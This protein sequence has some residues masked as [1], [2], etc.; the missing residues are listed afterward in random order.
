MIFI[1]K[2]GPDANTNLQRLKDQIDL[3]PPYM[4]FESVFDDE[5]GK[6]IKEIRNATKMRH[7]ITRNEIITKSK[8]TS[9]ESA[10][11]IARG[12]TAPIL[13]FDEFEFTSRIKTIVENSAPTYAKASENAKKNGGLYARIITSTPG[14]LD[15]P[16]GQESQIILE[17]TAKWTEEMYDWSD[18]KIREYVKN[19]SDNDIVYIE[20]SYRQLGL[21]EEW[22]E[23]QA[24]KIGN[25]Q[26]VKREILLQRLRG[27]SNSPFAPEDIEYLINNIQPVREELFLS[28]SY[29][30]DI[31]SPIKRRT[32]YLIG[33]DC[34]T[35]TGGD[36]NAITII[37]P[38]TIKPVAEFR[39]KYTGETQLCKLLIELITKHLPRGILIIER[40][41]VG[42]AVI[43]ILLH[44]P[45]SHNLYFD[46]A[47]D[48]LEENINRNATAESMLKRK[49]QSKKFYGVYT[50][51]ASRQD[52]MAILMRHVA[53]YK[54]NFITANV[55]NDI[56]RLI[57]K[58]SGKIEAGPGFHDD[59][60]MSY[61]V[62][63][64]VYYHGDNLQL[65]GF[66]KGSNDI[67]NQNQGTK[68]LED[69]NTDFL[70]DDIVNAIR[71]EEELE[72][73]SYDNILRKALME[74]QK[75]SIQTTQAGMVRNEI[76][77]NANEDMLNDD[78][79]IS[80]DFFDELN[81]L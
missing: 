60:I 22:F 70:P 49:A 42:D 12:L 43:D 4:K 48:L 14:D 65:F 7:P 1:N 25:P 66:V 37:D 52:M 69:V 73:N 62:A 8:A 24:R 17:G 44:S 9:I 18:E 36:F 61:L 29:R 41:S 32:P 38:Y 46:K 74:S 54:D 5:S 16:S 63:M 34:S 72:K 50:G 10:L 11:N 56:S 78:G 20:Y 3:L 77:S 67:E 47:K 30:F 80:I 75:V 33:V 35:G 27:S 6:N 58:T 13:H 19:N 81:G 26:T 15:T 31:Y 64:Y 71:A 23:D 45:I 79:E 53:E 39:C 21:N 51:G 40:N 57:T 55:I 2:S 76:Y 59:S 28:E 68:R